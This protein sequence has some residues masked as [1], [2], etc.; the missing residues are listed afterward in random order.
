MGEVV[1]N[2]QHPARRVN[3]TVSLCESHRLLNEC[4]VCGGLHGACHSEPCTLAE[5]LAAHPTDGVSHENEDLALTCAYPELKLDRDHGRCGNE[6][7]GR[8]DR[9]GARVSEPRE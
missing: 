8:S 6:H 9:E 2:Q 3:G 1:G 4:V 7:I 5:Q